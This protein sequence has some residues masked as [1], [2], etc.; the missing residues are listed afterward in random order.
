MDSNLF[1]SAFEA[2]GT[3]VGSLVTAGAVIVAVR[4]YKQPIT[5]RIKII[6]NLEVPITDNS[7]TE[8]WAGIGVTNTGTRPIQV[9]NILLNIGKRNLLISSIQIDHPDIPRL[10]FPIT[11]QPE[12]KIEMHLQMVRL[13]YAL[14]KQVKAKEI[15][16]NQKLKILVSDTANQKHFYKTKWSVKD[17]I[18][19][20]KES[21]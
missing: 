11:L 12:E 3:T 18:K 15:G 10:L 5:K 20:A 13:G 14:D 6:F 7:N 16:Y 1:W 2:I 4:Q 19:F 21:V 9:T 17:F 8:V